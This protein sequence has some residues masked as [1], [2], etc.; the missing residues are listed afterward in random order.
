MNTLPIIFDN[1]IFA[2]QKS[3]G[4]SVVWQELIQRLLCTPNLLL[5]FIEYNQEQENLNRKILNIPQEYLLKKKCPLLQLFRY[6]NPKIKNKSKFIFHS[7]Y[8]RT[9][10]NKQA[11][12]ITTVHDFTYEYFYSGLKKQ[13]HSWQKYRAIRNSDFIICISENTKKDLLKFLPEI[14]EKKVRVIYNGVSDDYYPITEEIS[15]YLPFPIYSYIIFIGSREKYKNFKLTVDAIT[16]SNYKLVIVGAKLSQ[17]ELNFLNSKIP[18]RYKEMGR[19]DNI[20][21]N[22]L[23]NGAF[24]LIYPSQYEG[25]GIPVLEAQKAGCPVVAYRS[26]SIPEII[27]ATPLL[28]N[29]LTADSIENCLNILTDIEAR[30]SIIN[31]GLENARRFTWDKMYEQVLELYEEA[32]NSKI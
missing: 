21:L 19:I 31:K 20:T 2:L 5:Y 23:Y 30:K 6:L 29:E 17:E 3:G 1:I 15:S 8:Y 12:N 4:I 22:R 10:S 32:W 24:A 27:G 9:C 16:S 25:F 26:S 28:L 18:G 11:I 13:I 14:D 7:S